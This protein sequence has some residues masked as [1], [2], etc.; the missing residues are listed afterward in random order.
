[1]IITAGVES[2]MSFLV[3]LMIINLVLSA[4]YALRMIYTVTVMK[5]TSTSRKAKE[6]PVLM[7][8]P[9]LFLAVTSILMGIYPSPFMS[10]AE[11]TVASLNS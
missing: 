6:A 7:L 9:I 1:M 10:F 2:G 3:F 5:E 4:A 11:A 8:I